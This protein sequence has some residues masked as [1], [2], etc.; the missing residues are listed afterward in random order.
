MSNIE[1]ITILGST[2]SIGTQTLDVC[3]MHGIKPTVL[4]A[5]HSTALLEKQALEFK[6]DTVCI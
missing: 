4:C 1:N 2:G 6:P 3:R 5:A